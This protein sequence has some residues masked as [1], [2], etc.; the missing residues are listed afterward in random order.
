LRIAHLSDLHFGAD[1]PASVTDLLTDLTEC[2]PDLVIVSG[3]LTMRARAAQF[4]SARALLDALP[5]PWLSVPGNHDLPLF[6]LPARAL[7][8]RY[9]YRRGVDRDAEPARRFGDAMVLGIDSTRRFYWTGGRVSGRQAARIRS[10]FGSAGPAGLRLLALHHPVFASVELPAAELVRGA[11]RLLRAAADARVDVVLCGHHHV[12][13]SIDLSALY[14]S[15]GRR[16]IGVMAG[17][18]T[19]HRVRA[20]H[21]Q[22]YNVLEFADDRLRLEVRHRPDGRFRISS[23]EEWTRGP[24]GW[25]RDTAAGSR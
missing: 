20:G 2:P 15:A 21:V 10:V 3:D 9:S 19:S 12:P 24:D 4:A 13:A 14:S 1:D 11:G 25:R 23:A 16:M 18:A 8:P 6:R 7:R 5:A 17:T 22:S